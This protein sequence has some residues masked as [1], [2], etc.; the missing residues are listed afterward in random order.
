MPSTL[1]GGAK[2]K[3][4]AVTTSKS[5]N[6]TKKAKT[7]QDNHPMSKKGELKTTA[8]KARPTNKAQKNRDVPVPSSS[9]PGNTTNPTQELHNA[10][11]KSSLRISPVDQWNYPSSESF[12]SSA[13][14]SPEDVANPRVFQRTMRDAEGRLHYVLK[15]TQVFQAIDWRGAGRRS[16]A[17]GFDLD[18]CDKDDDGPVSPK[19]IPGVKKGDFALQSGR[20]GSVFYGVVE[21]EM[22]LDPETMS[23]FYPGIL[24]MYGKI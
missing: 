20:N 11:E 23:P 4:D 17:G 15:V 6:L 10:A 14:S 2:R 21:G 13:P 24:N 3:I 1:R 19:S 22:E 12:S 7:T 9:S 8:P 5:A 16:G 18:D